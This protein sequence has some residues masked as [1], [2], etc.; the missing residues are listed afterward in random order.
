MKGLGCGLT[1]GIFP[2]T[3]AV[4]D[5]GLPAPQMRLA[6]DLELEEIG[7]PEAA[8]GHGL[9]KGIDRVPLRG[10]ERLWAHQG[11]RDWMEER[12]LSLIL[13]RTAS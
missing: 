6:G 1:P 5:V 9:E 13:R 4:R 7:D 8:G 12:I 2:E 3:G 11:L 10:T